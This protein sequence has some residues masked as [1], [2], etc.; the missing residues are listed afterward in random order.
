M[1]LSFCQ[2]KRVEVE[3]VG[4]GCQ[5]KPFLLLLLRAILEN[6]LDHR[7]TSSHPGTGKERPQELH[8][9][10]HAILG[11]QPLPGATFLSASFTLEQPLVLRPLQSSLCNYQPNSIS[12]FFSSCDDA[13]I[14]AVA[15][16][17]NL[18]A[19]PLPLVHPCPHNPLHTSTHHVLSVSPCNLSCGCLLMFGPA[20]LPSFQYPAS[21]AWAVEVAFYLVFGLYFYSPS[22]WMISNAHYFNLSVILHDLQQCLSNSS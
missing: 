4:W 14:H 13:F 19:Y 17:R 12:S 15:Q 6:G 20:T 3:I 9:S 10:C 18:G 2:V 21:L 1:W 7:S 16:G 5:G 11:S 8:T 22:A